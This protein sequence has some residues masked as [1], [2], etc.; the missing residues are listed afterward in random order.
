M[1]K[2]RFTLPGET[3]MEKEIAQLVKLW[4]VDA[5][6]DSD[7]TQLSQ[8]IIDMGLKVYSTLCLIRQ[9]VSATQRSRL[10][11]RTTIAYRSAPRRGEKAN[12]LRERWE[13]EASSQAG[14]RPMASSPFRRLR[15]ATGMGDN[16]A[17]RVSTEGQ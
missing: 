1:E 2:G 7:G 14:R 9:D 3:G 4:G 5:V 16:R 10:A 15:M 12:V 11:R 8:E 13:R 17:L 6:R